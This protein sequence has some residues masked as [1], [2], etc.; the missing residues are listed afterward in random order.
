[1]WKARLHPAEKDPFTY[2]FHWAYAVHLTHHSDPLKVGWYGIVRGRD[3]LNSAKFEFGPCETAERA[4]AVIA[5][6]LE[7]KRVFQSLADREDELGALT[8]GAFL[9]IVSGA[10]SGAASVARGL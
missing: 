7:D 5:D 1:V 4:K 6:W 10:L 3:A 9:A 8:P 2:T